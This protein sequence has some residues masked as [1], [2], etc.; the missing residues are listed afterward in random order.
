MLPTLSNLLVEAQ[1]VHFTATDLDRGIPCSQPSFL[2]I[3]LMVWSIP[4]LMYVIAFFS[5]L[6]QFVRGRF[7]GMLV[8]S[9]P[10]SHSPAL[11]A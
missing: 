3:I 8:P 11:K 2:M 9:L 1:G 4:A 7:G 10:R 6:K 5:E